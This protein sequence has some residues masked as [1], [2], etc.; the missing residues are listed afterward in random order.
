MI[1]T[2]TQLKRTLDDLYL[3]Y[4]TSDFIQT[5]PIQ[6]VHRYK[7]ERD[8]EIVGFIAALLSFGQ[9][10]KLIAFIDKVLNHLGSKPYTS[11]KQWEI[12]AINDLS[13]LTYRF[14]KGVDLIALFYKL[15][16]IIKNYETLENLFLEGYLPEVSLKNAMSHFVSTF[17]NVLLSKEIDRM[18]EGRE[19]NC[20]F[21][22][23]SPKAGSA[24]KRFNMFLRWMV[25]KD[26]VDIGL[27]NLPASSLIIPLD[28]HV[29]RI[30]KKLN[31]TSRKQADW[32][33]AEEI[34]SRLKEFDPCDP[35]KYDFALFGY[36]LDE[37]NQ[38]LVKG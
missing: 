2:Q 22:L 31:L 8:Q 27:W 9:R 35:I 1:V 3:R 21:L 10:E 33:M 19:R 13:H 29:E 11:I 15:H 4:N 5:D 23:P 14:I 7:D 6:F 28:T 12:K 37:R 18:I 16:Q 25:R 24:C 17:D 32:K 20:R 30:S 26:C 34:S 36:G 38:N